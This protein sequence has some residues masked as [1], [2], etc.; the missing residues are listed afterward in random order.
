VIGLVYLFAGTVSDKP[1]AF[2]LHLVG[3]AL[4]GGSLVYWWHTSDAQ[5]ALISIVS[6]VYVLIAYATKRSSW[7]VLGTI[8]FFAAT[9][10]YVVGSPF[11]IVQN[12]IAGWAPS[13]AFASLGFWLVVLGLRGRRSVE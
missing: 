8:G 9:T 7:A 1:S 5:W 12:G 6:L 4:I 11:A 13:V 3:G 2:W 10:H